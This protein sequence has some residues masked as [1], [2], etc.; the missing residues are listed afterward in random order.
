VE[1]VLEDAPAVLCSAPGSS[2]S[3]NF[4]QWL[5][6]NEEAQVG[7]DSSWSGVAPGQTAARSSAD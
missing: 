6:K 1:T 3:F 7:T 5:F 2:S 4:W